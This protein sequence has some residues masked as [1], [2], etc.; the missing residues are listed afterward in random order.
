MWVAVRREALRVFEDMKE[1]IRK[2]ISD[3]PKLALTADIWT[4][5]G[6][7]SSYLGITAH[8]IGPD[9]QRKKLTLAV[10]PM[11]ASH[12]GDQIYILTTNVLREWH[13]SDKQVS[14]VSINV[15]VSFLAFSYSPA[16]LKLSVF[17]KQ[18]LFL[19]WIHFFRLSP[20]MART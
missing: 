18:S 12:T 15:S 20:I 7:T 11:P 8:Y 17:G 1:K 3:L 9:D 16:A 5:K 4:K 2:E 19:E 14:K 6:M 13:I 10:R